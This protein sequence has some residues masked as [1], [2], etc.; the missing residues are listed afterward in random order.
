VKVEQQQLH[1][2]F[3]D[4]WLF[5]CRSNLLHYKII[6]VVKLLKRGKCGNYCGCLQFLTSK[7]RRGTLH[8]GVSIDVPSRRAH[9]PIFALNRHKMV[10]QLMCVSQQPVQF[11]GIVANHF[12]FH[13]DYSPPK[14]IP[15]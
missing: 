8:I 3:L 14:Q 9:G 4:K 15:G 11:D 10:E 7:E 12:N 13:T 1:F 6:S 2:A 5:F